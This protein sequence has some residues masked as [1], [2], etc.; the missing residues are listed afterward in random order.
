MDLEPYEWYCVSDSL[1]I[2]KKR[3]LSSGG[4]YSQGIVGDKF[5]PPIKKLVDL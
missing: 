2:F 4:I 5:S 1:G 3:S